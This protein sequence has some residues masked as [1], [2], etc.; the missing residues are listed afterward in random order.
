VSPPVDGGGS[1]IAAI[2]IVRH[3]RLEGKGVGPARLAGGNGLLRAR[4]VACV[5][6][7]DVAAPRSQQFRNLAAHACTG[8][9]SGDDGDLS[10][11]V[12]E[13]LF[14]VGAVLKSIRTTQINQLM[15]GRNLTGLDAFS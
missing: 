2:R 15:I 7:N 10:L 11:D 12:H 6:H 13:M 5:I 4:L 9:G 14:R 8:A 3:V 1:Q